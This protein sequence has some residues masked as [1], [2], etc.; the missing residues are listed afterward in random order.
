VL[1]GWNGGLEFAEPASQDESGDMSEFDIDAIAKR[2]LTGHGDF[3][4]LEAALVA[5]RH[6]ARH[7]GLFEA[8]KMVVDRVDELLPA[9]W[10]GELH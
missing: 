3:A 6:Y 5:D 1:P 7:L 2:Y 9:A 4:W 10:M 8:W